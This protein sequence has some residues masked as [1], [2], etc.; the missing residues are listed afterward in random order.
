MRRL[1]PRS[2]RWQAS[3]WLARRR[4]ARL[5]SDL[6]AMAR[7]GDVIVAGPWLGEVGFELLYWVPFLAWFAEEF[8]V[9]PGRLLVVSRGGTASWYQPF[10]TRY[11]DVF[12]SV[13]PEAFKAQHDAR[14]AE[15]GEQKQTR[16]TA[17]E[18]DLL[19]TIVDRTGIRGYRLLHPSV[20]YNVL[21]PFWW[22]H[23]P[24]G[25]VHRHARYRKLVAPDAVGF[26]QL[27]A[28]YVAAKFYFNDCFP[29]TDANR[30]FAEQSL[31][32]LTGQGPVVA[33]STGLNIDDHGGVRV[34]EHGVM[35]LPEGIG[36][37]HNLQLQS[38]VVARAR[39]FV[40]TYGGFSYLAPLHGV[41]SIA[42]YSDENG[43]SRKHLEVARSALEKIGLRGLLQVHDTAQGM[44]VLSAT[45]P[46]RG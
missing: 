4:S 10:A 29:A 43:F 27:P 28:S 39:A 13:S 23:A 8:G 38:A 34:D 14:V 5:A 44:N 1:I 16:V 22:G 32:A 36:A 17:F 33:L 46:Q 30:G 6:R 3:R 11:A 41:P 35:H 2:V 37:A 21:N 12:D 40:G 15:I 18:R 7:S 25:W 20:M 42:Y 24:I 45:G 19:A 9:E 31:A 26:P